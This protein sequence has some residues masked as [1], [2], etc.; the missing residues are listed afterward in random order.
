MISSESSG[1]RTT[2]R[3]DGPRSSLTKRISASRSARRRR[4]ARRGTRR[5]RSQQTRASRDAAC[6]ADGAIGAAPTGRCVHARTARSMRGDGACSVTAKSAGASVSIVASARVGRRRRRASTD[7]GRDRR[8]RGERRRH[9]ARAPARESAAWRQLVTRKPT[10]SLT[11]SP[12]PVA[13]IST[14]YSP[15][16]SARAADR[17]PC[18][19]GAGGR[20]DREVGHRLPG[21]VEQLAR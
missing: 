9:R 18:D 13:V 21:A 2:T 1:L 14:M 12:S 6:A 20:R 4:P 5:E 3:S 10:S 16:G 8:R 7:S 15:G 19:R 11:G 17:C